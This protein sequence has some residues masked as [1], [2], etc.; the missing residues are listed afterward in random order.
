MSVAQARSIVKGLKWHHLGF[1][2]FWAVTFVALMS[3]ADEFAF[4]STGF[5]V[6]KQLSTIVAVI[7][8]AVLSIRRGSKAYSPESAYIAGIALSAGSLLYYLAFFLADFSVASVAIAS[9]LVGASQGAFFVMWQSFYASEGTSRTTV[10]I[11][12]SALCSVVLCIA[13]GFLPT[14]WLVVCGV[15]VL[16]ALGAWTLR[17]SL[18]EVVPYEAEP[19]TRERRRMLLRDMGRP[20]FCVCAIGFVWKMIGCVVPQGNLGSFEGIMLGMSCAT[21]VVA[22]IELFTERGFDMLRVYQVIFPLIT[23]VF[24]LPTFFGIGW[25]GAVSVFT[26][27]GF[28]VVNLLLLITCAAYASRKAID[29]SLVYALCVAPTLVSLLLGDAVGQV[30]AA[31]TVLDFTLVVDVL[32]VCVYVLTAALFLA[33]LGRNR[34]DVRRSITAAPQANAGECDFGEALAEN[35]A[36]AK[37]EEPLVQGACAVEEEPCVQ[38]AL[39]SEGESRDVQ[40]CEEKS[41]AALRRSNDAVPMVPTDE[42]SGSLEERLSSLDLIDPLSARECEVADLMRHGNT[43]AAIARRLYISENTVRG[44]TKSIYRKLGIH[45][46]QEL[47][48]LLN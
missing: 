19:L 18:A 32:F 48:D 13:I 5:S 45:S 14:E 27:F 26:M 30:A 39:S 2:F 36:R 25:L 37:S 38:K 6:G 41:P 9:M 22:A 12:L 20:V 15:I 43:V 21:L 40:Q 29:S 24:L 42:S 35:A 34:S 23:G 33:S 31:H 7:V 10:Y 3:P 17:K 44:H 1:C 8:A 47:I 11:P 16:P 4:A 28:E 46:K